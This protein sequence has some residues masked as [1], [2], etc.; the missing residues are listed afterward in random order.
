MHGPT[1]G[2]DRERILPLVGRADGQAGR[3]A[4]DEVIGDGPGCSGMGRAVH[5]VLFVGDRRDHHAASELRVRLGQHLGHFQERH[6]RTLHVAGTPAVNAA[7]GDRAAEGIVVPGH[8][9]GV[10][11]PRQA[12]HVA[13]APRAGGQHVG[14]TFVHDVEG[15]RPSE[16]VQMLGQPLPCQLLAGVVG[17]RV[18]KRI[19]A[20]DLHQL[21]GSSD[22]PTSVDQVVEVG[23]GAIIP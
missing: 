16:P 13:V 18:V 9:N 20:G 2:P 21:T 8:A 1:L 11:V 15:G 5:R 3:L 14:A 7:V 12:E 4:H 19:D 22:E 6:Q 23:H 17:H 10:E